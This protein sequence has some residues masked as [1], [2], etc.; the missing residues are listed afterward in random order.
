MK[1]LTNIDLGKNELQNAVFQNLAADP[2]AA[3]SK[4]GQV[5]Y[6][7]TTSKL[8]QYVKD[9]DGNLVWADI[10]SGSGE[11]SEVEVPV[12][13]AG[14][15][16]ID[17][18]EKVVVEV[19]SVPT[20]KKGKIKI[21]DD[22]KTV[23]ELVSS[24]PATKSGD[25]VPLLSLVEDLL[26][27]KVDVDGDTMTGNLK[28]DAKFETTGDAKFGA[29]VVLHDDPVDD[30]EAST[31][32][33]V[34]DQI[35]AATKFKALVVPKLPADSG[36]S[37]AKE[38]TFY[39]MPMVAPDGVVAGSS[40]EFIFDSSKTTAT[41]YTEVAVGTEI[42][43]DEKMYFCAPAAIGP[44]APV[45]WAFSKENLPQ[46]SPCPDMSSKG[47]KVYSMPV[48]NKWVYMG[49]TNVNMKDYL[50]SAGGEAK[51]VVVTFTKASAVAEPTSATSL[52]TI[53]GL[54][55]KDIEGIEVSKKTSVAMPASGTSV[56]AAMKTIDTKYTS[57]IRWDAHLA[58]SAESIMVDHEYNTSTDTHT[59]SI[60]QPLTGLPL[61]IDIYYLAKQ[62]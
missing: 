57:T 9:E 54:V 20:E 25:E 3:N 10:G 33:Y 56:S 53:I 18:T 5:Y 60:A 31:K 19:T 55:A 58:G 13:K 16:T 17:G 15:I 26:D 43:W 4:E 35:E 27:D 24:V 23:V 36:T 1:F 7:T 32:K 30:K 61:I 12:E 47:Y 8:R 40:V 6:N 42:K 11:G 41:A 2:S 34:D 45:M 52:A 44:S 51:D 62:I 21:G 29:K 38:L 50:K 37:G 49:T 48:N 28:V 22:E 46:G 59:F 14:K 39:F